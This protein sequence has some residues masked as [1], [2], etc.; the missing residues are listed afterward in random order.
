MQVYVEEAS[1]VNWLRSSLKSNS[2]PDL[3]DVQV[4]YTP[5]DEQGFKY[6]IIYKRRD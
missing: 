6:K 5:E 3:L 4:I 2:G 1:S